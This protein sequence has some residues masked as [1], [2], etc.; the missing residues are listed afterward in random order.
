M[1]GGCPHNITRTHKETREDGTVV[2]HVRCFICEKSWS[3]TDVK[4][5]TSLGQFT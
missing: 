2:L 3:R 1:V 5:Q 4:G